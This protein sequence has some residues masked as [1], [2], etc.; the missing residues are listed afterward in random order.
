MIQRAKGAQNGSKTEASGQQERLAKQVEK[1]G[2]FGC[3]TRVLGGEIRSGYRALPNGPH[4][5]KNPE[6]PLEIPNFVH[7]TFTAADAKIPLS[8]VQ[9]K[10]EPQDVVFCCACIAPSSAT[11]RFRC[12]KQ[13]NP[14]RWRVSRP[15]Y[16]RKI[17]A[18]PTPSPSLDP[19]PRAYKAQNWC[20]PCGPLCELWTT[21]TACFPRH[22]P[23]LRGSRL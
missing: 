9:V 13:K 4:G 6:N 19:F 12:A 22:P 7:R 3:M 2:Q 18:N 23:P 17:T 15:M 1:L 10:R 11:A 14:L 21:R 20:I 8:V 5:R 16:V